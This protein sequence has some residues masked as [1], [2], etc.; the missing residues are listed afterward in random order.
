MH[1]ES[2]CARLIHA[3]LNP[4][5]ISCSICTTYLSHMSTLVMPSSRTNAFDKK[6]VI[7]ALSCHILHLAAARHC[8][9]RTAVRS[10]RI[11]ISRDT[12]QL[13]SHLARSP[14]PLRPAADVPRSIRYQPTSLPTRT[15]VSLG[16]VGPRPRYLCRTHAQARTSK[17]GVGRRSF[18]DPHMASPPRTP[19]AAAAV[20]RP[21]H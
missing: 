17:T 7:H 9:S 18:K 3:C 5:T 8:K 13:T 14:A 16:K 6:Q 10:Q 1:L 4:Q 21:V 15:N 20:R 12:P 19:P 11:P 2:A